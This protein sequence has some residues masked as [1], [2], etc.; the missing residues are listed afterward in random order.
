MEFFYFDSTRNNSI[1]FIQKIFYTK[2][3]VRAESPA[4]PG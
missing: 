1:C 4:L 3:V 2:Q